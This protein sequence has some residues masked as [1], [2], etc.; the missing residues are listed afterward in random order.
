[1]GHLIVGV[2]PSGAGLQAKRGISRVS[3]FVVNTKLHHGAFRDPLS[4]VVDLDVGSR[5]PAG[6]TKSDPSLRCEPIKI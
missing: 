3:P 2:I 1:V 5:G 4:F 6:C